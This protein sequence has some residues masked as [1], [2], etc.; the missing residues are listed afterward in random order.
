MSLAPEGMEHFDQILCGDTEVARDGELIDGITPHSSR[1]NKVTFISTSHPI[2]M[3]AD[4]TVPENCPRN[5]DLNAT[6]EL[7]CFSCAQANLVYADG[8]HIIVGLR[9]LQD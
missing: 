4:G 5:P 2:W 1:W 3:E 7:G 6:K 8:N 9:Q